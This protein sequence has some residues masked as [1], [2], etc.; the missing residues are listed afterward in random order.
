MS[1]CLGFETWTNF[2]QKSQDMGAHSTVVF[3]DLTGST[4]VF[5]SMGNARAAETVTR[6]TQWIAAVCEAHQG[7]VVKT[8][9]DGV[10]AVFQS[11]D[12]ATRAA[13][14]MQRNHQKRIQT[15]PP[16]LRM[17][18]QIGMA[19]G[20]VLEVDGDCYGDAVNLA[21]RLS[22][23]AGPRQIWATQSV[24]D[25][26]NGQEVRHR[27]LGPINIRGKSE[28]PVVYRID[29][30]DESLEFLTMPATLAQMNR[31]KEASFGKIELSWLDV[32]QTFNATDL[33]IYLGRVDDA[34]FVVNDP[35]VSRLHARLESRKGS[36][37]LVDVSTY[38]TWVQF[39]N[40]TGISGEI[41]LRRD[42]CVLHGNGQ[43]SL[44]APLS[45]LSAPVVNFDTTGGLMVLSR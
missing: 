30:Q 42:E 6:L 10:L 24:I 17:E 4:A 19:S 27:S 21:S 29:W 33:P 8:L 40:A 14:E 31:P 5:E 9:G 25:E 18:L 13:L 34:E 43:I 22:D 20:D 32:R 7:R 45:D 38:G 16:A 11:G 41:A 1:I 44:G 39:R 28:M 15:W 35:R 37:V 2:H 23:L 12:W 26:L 36:C 3:A